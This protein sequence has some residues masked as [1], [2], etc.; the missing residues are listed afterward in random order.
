[1]TRLRRVADVRRTLGLR[2]F[3]AT[4]P[5]WA[6]RP[7]FHVVVRDLGMPLPA[8]SPLA[9]VRWAPLSW[10]DAAAIT[11]LNPALSALEQRR[12]WEEGQICVGG[13]LDAALVHYWWETTR[14]AYLPYLGRSCR[15]AR[16]DVC[17][18]EAF[19]APAARG[20]GISSAA[21]VLA[22]HRSRDQGLRRSIGFIAWWNT[23]SLRIGWSTTDRTTVGTVGYIRLGLWRRHFATGAVRLAGSKD[24]EVLTSGART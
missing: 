12:R 7:E 6:L 18:V 17:V 13:W 8:I 22:L 2:R 23:P 14:P 5:R 19:T 9:G 21:A 4:L 1:M 20:R 11:A 10:R 16:G 3:L 24:F 15:P